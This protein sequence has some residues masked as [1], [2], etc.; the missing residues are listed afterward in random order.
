MTTDKNSLS[1]GRYLRAVR[2]EK[3]ISLEEVSKETK[4][5]VDNLLLIEKED[6]GRLPA[7]VFIKGFLRA[8]AKAIG[9]DGDEAVRRYLSSLRTFQGAADS[10]VDLPE[11][12]S[13]FWFRLGLSLGALMCIVALSVF[14][15]SIFQHYPSADGQFNKQVTEDNIGENNQEIVSKPPQSQDFVPDFAKKR[16]EKFEEKLLLEIMT[17]EDTWIKIIMD[18][19]SPKQYSLKPGDRLELEASSGFNLLIG[20]AAGVNLSLNGKPVKVP[21]KSGEVVN[22][23]I[24]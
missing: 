23:Q 7:G 14:A 1:F 10:R 16:S 6:H 21:G 19:R 20:N 12:G 17:I 3:G 9:A 4:I 2:L 18:G 15:T 8:Y 5:R 13:A 24:P 22:V 11:S